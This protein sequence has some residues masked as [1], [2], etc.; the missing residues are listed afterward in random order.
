MNKADI[1][2]AFVG[3]Q[4]QEVQTDG[5]FEFVLTF[6]DGSVLTVEDDSCEGSHFKVTADVKVKT[7]L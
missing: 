2:E 1:L 7:T 3:K 5:R 4:V 6:T